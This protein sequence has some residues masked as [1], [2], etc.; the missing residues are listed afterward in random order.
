M[1]SRVVVVTGG[2]TGLGRAMA[3]AL[4]ASGHRVA[5]V[6]RTTAALD[7][8]RAEAAASGAADRLLTVTGSV[9]EPAD[10]A[11]T[12]DATVERFGRVDGLV[13]NAGVHLPTDAPAPPFHDLTEEQWRAIVETH[14]FGA[15]SMTRLVVPHLLAQGWGRIV[16]HETSYATMVR[17]GFSA[18]GA[19]KAGLEAATV[20][21]SE[22]LRG[23]GVTV[24]AIL[25]GGAANVPRISE[26]LFR[27]RAK[28]VQPQQMGAPIAWLLSDASGDVTGCRITAS[29]WD[30]VAAEVPNR[31]AAVTP[32]GWSIAAG[33]ST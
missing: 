33:R 10:C 12:V 15:F 16:N 4:L 29:A 1:E 27:D 22:E 23:T 28:L 31:A 30:P 13:N 19:A 8:V 5:I 7:D 17:A 32:A 3:L 21:W 20:A 14:L 24:N 25:P 26:R 6:S 2:A 18:Y 11:R 9:R